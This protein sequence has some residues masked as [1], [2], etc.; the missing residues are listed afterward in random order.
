MD[1][2]GPDYCYRCKKLC[3]CDCNNPIITHDKWI[4]ILEGA[5]DFFKIGK[6]DICDFEEIEAEDA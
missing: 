2:A 3:P 4:E 6:Q 5:M 1:N